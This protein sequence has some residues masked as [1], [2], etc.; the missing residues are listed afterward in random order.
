MGRAD[1]PLVDAERHEQ[2]DTLQHLGARGGRERSFLLAQPQG[3]HLAR[4]EARG[5]S[6]CP[7]L[8]CQRS[9]KSCSLSWRTSPS[10]T[11]VVASRSFLMSTAI[12]ASLRTRRVPRRIA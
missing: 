1:Q 7:L 12:V 8:A 2:V 9:L 11:S 3:Q 10:M 5:F 4:V 6:A